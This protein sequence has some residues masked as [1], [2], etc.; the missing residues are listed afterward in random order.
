MSVLPDAFDDD[1]E[2]EAAALVVMMVA[3][4]RHNKWLRK[5]RILYVELFLLG[6]LE[7]VWNWKPF[8]SIIDKFYIL[9][10]LQ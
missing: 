7:V 1:E 9:P 6:E 10:W 2:L 5:R 4:A 3:N 8:I